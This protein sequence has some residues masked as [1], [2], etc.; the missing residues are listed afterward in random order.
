MKISF[1]MIVLNGMPFIEAALKSIYDFAHEIIIVEGTVEKCIFAANQDGSS[2]D[3]TIKFI[4]SFPDPQN[5]IKLIQG[6]W[7]EKCE[8]Q[9]KALDMCSGDY[10]WLVDSD[11]VWRKKDIKEITCILKQ[12]S[13]IT[14]VNI[15]MVPFWKGFDYIM[16]SERLK[17]IWTPRIFK[18]DK[19]CLFIEHRP[20]AL[21]WKR[22][23]KTTEK[24]KLLNVGILLC[25]YS[26]VL[27]K[28][29]KQKIELYKRYGW[30]KIWGLDLDDWYSNCF[31]KWTPENR[32]EI[33]N[34]Y[35]IWTCDRSS[36]TEQF[37][38]I[39]PESIMEIKQCLK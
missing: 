10:I 17:G 7:P 39:H 38:G 25:H 29:V 27:E 35:G 36:N 16:S 8:M 14:Q 31:L 37:I 9:N 12:D 21:L 1:V 19:P 4:R 5:K 28:Q 34:K 11:E 23:D 33:E 3:G 13:T 20:P 18:L 32:E 26:Y 24:I 22:I 15:S 6:K 30:D 2:T